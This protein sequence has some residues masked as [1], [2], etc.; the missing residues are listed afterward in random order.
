MNLYNE[1]NHLPGG[2]KKTQR[3]FKPSFLT[4]TWAISFNLSQ[5]Y[6]RG[7]CASIYS[8][9]RRFPIICHFC[10]G[11]IWNVQFS[12]CAKIDVEYVILHFGVIKGV[13]TTMKILR[14]NLLFMGCSWSTN[15]NHTVEMIFSHSNIT[16]AQQRHPSNRTTSW[17]I[18]LFSLSFHPAQNFFPLHRTS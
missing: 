4:P 5:Y 2:P 14:K 13:L 10:H 16:M 18:H 17:L 15:L 9:Q 1:S 3:N 11:E 6:S 7:S 8:V 12:I